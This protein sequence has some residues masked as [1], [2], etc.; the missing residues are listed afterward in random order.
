SYVGRF[1]RNL[2]AQ[3][4]VMHF[5]NLRDPESGL[6][7]YQAMR[8]LIGHRHGATPIEQGPTIPYFE[9]VFPGFASAFGFPE[10]TSN[11]HAVYTFIALPSVGGFNVTDYTLIQ[12]NLVGNNSPVAFTDRAFVHPQYAT[13]MA[14]SSIAKSNYNSGQF[15][16]RQRLR[17]DLLF[18]FNYTLSHSLDNASGLQNTAVGSSAALIFDPTNLDSNYADSDF[19]VRHIINANWLVGLPFGRDKKFLNNLPK[20]A[21][22]IL[23]GWQLTGIFRWNSGFPTNVLRP[24]AFQRWATN[25]QVSS[26]MVAL[27]RQRLCAGRDVNGEPNIFCDPQEAFR[28]YRDP[29]PG[30]PGDRN[31]L[32]D[33]GYVS[34][35]AGLHKTFQMPWSE[36]QR[37]T[38]RWEV[39][40]VTNT[41]RLTTLSGVG[42]GLP[43]DP[44]LLGGDAP[45]TFGRFTATQTPLNETKA[46]RVMQFA[47][48]FQF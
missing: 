7:W 1:A 46:G 37:L 20:V 29:L 4:D 27:Q 47:L 43:G 25:W 24:F 19:D 16:L 28:N 11:T 9:N 31:K 6:N 13:L 21:D 23:G 42:L 44:F 22:A 5:N 32:R 48:R 40:N 17:N 33:P 39:F 36:E 35:D 26:G 12:S 2:L 18:D 14:W 38:F 10:G 41:Q 30:E 15:S 34:L 3:R 8:Q 45:E